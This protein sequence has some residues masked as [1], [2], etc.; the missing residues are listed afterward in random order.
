[1]NASSK[2]GGFTIVEMLLAVCILAVLMASVAVAFHG[3]LVNYRENEKI[4]R[5][6]HVAR[7]VLDRLMA[8]IR[9]ADGVEADL[10]RVT[11]V[12]PV[13]PEQI[14]QIEY[15]LSGGVLY[16]RRVVAGVEEEEPFISSDDDVQVV[17]FGPI[18]PPQTD[19]DDEGTTYITSLTVKLVLQAGANRFSLTAS[20]C[21]RRNQEY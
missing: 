17:S 14:T 21:P 5:T 7:V 1:M 4:A 8:D 16:Y 6:I 19:E 9:T 3:S 2:N 11:I 10:Q 18:L 13:N 12:P 20:A 15:E